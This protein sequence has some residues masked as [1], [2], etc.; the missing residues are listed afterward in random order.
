MAILTPPRPLVQRFTASDELAAS[1]DPT[2]TLCRERLLKTLRS[3]DHNPGDS[4]LLE[5]LAERD[6]EQAIRWLTAHRVTYRPFHN[7]IQ[8]LV[9]SS[10]AGTIRHIIEHWSGTPEGARFASQ[11]LRF[12]IDPKTPLLRG[13]NSQEGAHALMFGLDHLVRNGGSNG[14]K[15]VE[16]I[17]CYIATGM[18]AGPRQAFM[19]QFVEHANGYDMDSYGPPMDTVRNIFRSFGLPFPE[20]RRTHT[21]ASLIDTGN[22][23][24]EGDLASSCAATDHGRALEAR[25]TEQELHALDK[26][27]SSFMACAMYN[28]RAKTSIAHQRNI[29]E[30]AINLR[31]HFTDQTQWERHFSQGALPGVS[32]EE[33]LRALQTPASLMK[34]LAQALEAR[35]ITH[36]ASAAATISSGLQSDIAPPKDVS[37]V[38]PIRTACLM[39]ARA[40]VEQLCDALQGIH[41]EWTRDA[42]LARLEEPTQT[43]VRQVLDE[44]C[45]VV[46]L[47]GA[48]ARVEHLRALITG[49]DAQ[50]FAH[51]KAISPDLGLAE[52]KEHRA[53][54]IAAA[55]SLHPE[56]VLGQLM[57][58]EADVRLSDV[59]LEMTSELL[60]DR[61][62]GPLAL[63]YA[64]TTALELAPSMP[65]VAMRLLA[66]A[67]RRDPEAAFA[68]LE[69]LVAHA[70]S[71]KALVA[72]MRGFGDN[73]CAQC[74]LSIAYAPLAMQWER[75]NATES[76]Y[77]IQST[78]PE[79]DTSLVANEALLLSEVSSERGAAAVRALCEFVETHLD[80]RGVRLDHPRPEESPER[81][82]RR[83]ETILDEARDPSGRLVRA[84]ETWHRWH[85]GEI[86]LVEL[87]REMQRL[88]VARVRD[89]FEPSNPASEDD[90]MDYFLRQVF[91]RRAENDA[92][93]VGQR[94]VT[95]AHDGVELAN[96]A[97]RTWIELYKNHFHRSPHGSV[98]LDRTPRIPSPWEDTAGREG[99]AHGVPPFEHSLGTIDPPFSRTTYLLHFALG[100]LDPRSLERCRID[101]AELPITARL[102]R[103]FIED[104]SSGASRDDL[105]H[106][107]T[108]DDCEPGCTVPAVIGASVERSD[109]TQW[110]TY[111][112]TLKERVSTK[113][114]GAIPLRDL[115]AAYGPE[116]CAE[117]A[118]PSIPF[119]QLPVEWRAVIEEARACES[120]ARAVELVE[121]FVR[122]RY[123][124]HEDIGV[125]PAWAAFCAKNPEHEGG[126]RDLLDAVHALGRGDH[127]GGVI[128]GG[129]D[130][131]F[132]E[133]LAHLG[134]HSSPLGGYLMA[135]GEPTITNLCAHRFR[136]VYLPSEEGIVRGFVRD[137]TPSIT[138][139][140]QS[141]TSAGGVP[142]ERINFVSRESSRG[143]AHARGS[144]TSRRSDLRLPDCPET[145]TP[146]G[147]LSIPGCPRAIAIELA[148]LISEFD[149]TG[150]RLSGRELSLFPI[151]DKITGYESSIFTGRTDRL[152]ELARTPGKISAAALETLE[153]LAAIGAEEAKAVMAS[154]P[155]LDFSDLRDIFSSANFEKKRE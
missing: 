17:A 155:E 70:E 135:A 140:V 55:A 127:A 31:E 84:F 101:E 125:E 138:L 60:E 124:Y 3:I 147:Q 32:A 148:A 8:H 80:A 64:L 1:S 12:F 20:S 63:E 58:A 19:K 146:I 75:T 98:D 14:L 26:E 91:R 150:H 102:V 86:S 27:L 85:T 143:E 38:S 36:G 52:D 71:K 130:E 35:G 9:D 5:K 72:A 99:V 78:N 67:A 109:F 144:N 94:H 90:G 89:P 113:H 49:S 44:T 76:R 48:V 24:S 16:E 2:V 133:L 54:F 22:L 118:T 46:P 59:G 134:V 30:L 120:A 39:L 81:S 128:C 88:G 13:W 92:P 33:H 117:R 105:A 103:E 42:L 45:T 29:V 66:T 65:E 68:A 153:A 10:G 95:I 137:A 40:A 104:E 111:C 50:T 132:G 57:R 123:F 34:N 62:H 93:T 121:R 151:V 106:V 116:L 152:L 119:E 139:R 51:I 47:D 114:P 53:P 126:L 74:L 110:G 154:L 83:L 142:A 56:A 107:M 4:S 77:M 112:A 7:N 108:L 136:L 18:D 28:L 82:E 41:V 115:E 129:A 79:L 149:P 43:R 6:P 73:P 96:E 11:A 87:S 100:P 15:A 21:F 37:S 141:T 61:T 23:Y 145:Y 131:L 122:S 25:P 97:I 69:R